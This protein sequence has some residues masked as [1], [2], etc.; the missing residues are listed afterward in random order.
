M[1]YVFLYR[2]ASFLKF[3][4]AKAKMYELYLN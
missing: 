1:T 2:I 4:P 3:F